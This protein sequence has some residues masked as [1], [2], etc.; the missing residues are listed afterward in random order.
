[1]HVATRLATATTGTGRL[2]EH[3]LRHRIEHHD[4]RDGGTIDA[5]DV[6]TPLCRDLGPARRARRHGR[7]HRDP[8]SDARPDSV[9]ARIWALRVRDL[10]TYS[11]TTANSP[12]IL[13]SGDGTAGRW[14]SDGYALLGA[15][16]TT[17]RGITRPPAYIS[18]GPA[19][20]GH[21]VHH[22]RSA[23]TDDILRLQF[24]D[25]YAAGA[26][27]KIMY[28]P[29]EGLM[30]DMV[31]TAA[32][33]YVTGYSGGGGHARLPALMPGIVI[34][35]LRSTGAIRRSSP[36]ASCSTRAEASART[37][38]PT[39]SRPAP[40]STRTTRSEPGLRILPAWCRTRGHTNALAYLDVGG[41][42]LTV[43]GRRYVQ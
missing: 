27:G 14:V 21:G 36:A 26:E 20:A 10:G 41:A 24:P 4:P 33:V 39:P 38:L 8:G 9:R 35:R 3:D 40:Q 23:D 1:M 42:Y 17:Y 22:R 32:T 29:I 2:H 28:F 7:A 43:T 5:A 18:A 25:A 16:L 19:V 31:I 15:S 12:W 37:R 11:A 34:R 6:N 30:N 13:A